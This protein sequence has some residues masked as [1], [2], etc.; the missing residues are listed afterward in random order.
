[1]SE[2]DAKGWEALLAYHDGELRG[3]AR[4]RFEF[5]PQNMSQA[6]AQAVYDLQFAALEELDLIQSEFDPDYADVAERDA[7]LVV[8]VEAVGGDFA[9]LPVPT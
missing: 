3:L 4:W 8:A 5:G 7:E 2:L 9:D 1:M 6:D